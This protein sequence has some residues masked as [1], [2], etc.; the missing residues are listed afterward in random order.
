MSRV[1]AH[2][3]LPLD[4]G[5]RHLGRL[6][7]GVRVPGLAAWEFFP[8]LAVFGGPALPLSLRLL[9]TWSDYSPEK[10]G[11]TEPLVPLFEGSGVTFAAFLWLKVL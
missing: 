11:E 2:F 8:R 9:I 3:F 6:I 1:T 10:R 5:P 4:R 7:S